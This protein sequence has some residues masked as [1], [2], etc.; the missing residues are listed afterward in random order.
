V[1]RELSLNA[2]Q[3]RLGAFEPALALRASDRAATQAQAPRVGD[4]P[5][6]PLRGKHASLAA[7]VDQRAAH[8]TAPDRTVARPSVEALQQRSEDWSR[9]IS[10]LVREERQNKP[11]LESNSSAAAPDA[12][13]ARR[14]RYS[15]RPVR[16]T[17]ETS[18]LYELYLRECAQRELMRRERSPQLRRVH[19][20]KFDRVI[21]R[22]RLRH[23]ALRLVTGTRAEKR[24]MHAAARFAMQQELKVVRAR[25]AHDRRELAQAAKRMAWSDWL[26]ARAR[27]GD[28]AALEE[29]RRQHRSVKQPSPDGQRALAGAPV[30]MRA[31]GFRG[32][33][34]MV[35]KTGVVI[36]GGSLTGIR[37]DGHR[38]RVA[39]PVSH[40]V[41]VEALRVAVSRYGAAVRV[42]G[43]EAFKQT[44][45]AVAVA[46]NIEV[47]FDD[48]SLDA[49][50]QGR[51]IEETD[52]GRRNQPGRHHG[53]EQSR[54]THSK[55]A[56]HRKAPGRE[57][58]LRNMRVG[59]LVRDGEGPER[60][61]RKDVFA[62]LAGRTWQSGKA[63]RRAV[64][65]ALDIRAAPP[66]LRRGRLRSLST[67]N[68][69]LSRA[70]EGQQASIPRAERKKVTG[71]VTKRPVAPRTAMPS[72]GSGP[73]P[74][75]AIRTELT[76]RTT[77]TI[78]EAIAHYVGE[79]EAKRTRGMSDVLLHVPF[80]GRSGEFTFVGRRTVDGHALLLLRDRTRIIVLPAQQQAATLRSGD[81]VRVGPDGT[82]T[83]R[84]QGRRR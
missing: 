58:G 8:V 10:Q 56:A 33:V 44:V 11:H 20:A 78:E 54:P 48:A 26:L 12:I 62:H 18:K 32:V 9:L 34:D 39:G 45:V 50:R 21:Q 15:K 41:L 65:A 25:A 16:E 30:S 60:V 59:E 22:W 7:V 67:L 17:A 75:R 14:Q 64:R 53:R 61:L 84:S 70:K 19:Q 72:L 69:P 43:D 80:D 1:R 77:S 42:D 46:R 66:P 40:A 52:S 13:D 31:R 68:V 29:L 83:S 57:D 71:V 37:D 2:L 6:S 63:L 55:A 28:I 74:S 76:R 23:S 5:P 49:R 36:Y 73:S 47:T 51:Q 4:A 27:T 24:L 38:L 82:I 3:K 79:R 81:H 35:T